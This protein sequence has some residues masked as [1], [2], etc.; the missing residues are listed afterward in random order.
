MNFRFKY[1]CNI[2][3]SNERL[4]FYFAIFFCLR[5]SSSFLN[6]YSLCGTSVYSLLLIV[7]LLFGISIP[8][9]CGQIYQALFI[10]SPISHVFHCMVLVVWAYSLLLLFPSFF[11]SFVRSFVRSF[12]L[13]FV[14]SSSFTNLFILNGI[15]IFSFSCYRFHLC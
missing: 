7:I 5:Y 13:S 14:R 2:L 12:F 4:T 6:A 8:L 1:H 9:L 10:K 3:V 15:L 11:L